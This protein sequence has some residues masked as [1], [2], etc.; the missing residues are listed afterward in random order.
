MTVDSTAWKPTGEQA[1]TGRRRRKPG[2]VAWLP[3]EL[4][5]SIF[6]AG[7][8]PT[9]L[10]A[11]ANVMLATNTMRSSCC[12]VHVVC[13]C[14]RYADE[15]GILPSKPG[16]GRAKGSSFRLC[17]QG[18]VR[19][20]RRA[21]FSHHMGAAAG[22]CFPTADEVHRLPGRHGGYL[23]PR[24]STR[25]VGRRPRLGKRAPTS[26]HHPCSLSFSR[27]VWSGRDSHAYDQNYS[28]TLT[29]SPRH[30][31]PCCLGRFDPAHPDATHILC[32]AEPGH[33]ARPCPSRLST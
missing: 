10:R 9:C 6:R 18:Q 21:F 12:P 11:S 2:G 4:G 26:A 29:H 31:L 8:C 3:V 7:A 14:R 30:N 19:T 25:Q 24:S 17:L 1:D 33:P 15:G 20:P 16:V 32:P 5:K 22:V 23:L 13:S 28:V 27:P